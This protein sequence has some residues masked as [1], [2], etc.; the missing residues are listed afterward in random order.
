M[1]EPYSPEKNLRVLLIEDNPDDAL[2]IRL[3]L[4]QSGYHPQTLQVNTREEYLAVLDERVDVILSD[5]ALPRFNAIEALRLVQEKGLDLPFIIIS[6]VIDEETALEAL[7]LGA[8]DYLL[9]DR[10][11]RLGAAV[12]H[13]IEKHRLQRTNR[14]ILTALQESNAR[15]TALAEHMPGLIFQLLTR[16]DGAPAFLYASPWVQRTFGLAPETLRERADLLLDRIHPEDR[17]G[18]FETLHQAGA[19]GAPW[20]WEGRMQA[21]DRLLW[22]RG[23]ARPTANPDGT[24]LWNGLLIDLT[25]KKRAEQ[26]LRQSEVRYRTLFEAAHDAIV[27]LRE[28]HIIDCNRRFLTL[29]QQPREAVL[30]RHPAD[31]SP[32]GF[33]AG[34]DPRSVLDRHLEAAPAGKPRSCEWVFRR[35]DGTTFDAELS[36][37]AFQ[38]DDEVL[39]QVLVR[40]ITDQKRYEAGLIE[41]RERAEEMSRLKSALL[42]NMSHE[43]RTP[44]TG[45]LG[46]AEILQDLVSGEARKM[47]DMIQ[48]SARRLMTTLNSVLDLAQLESGSMPLHLQPVNLTEQ[49]QEALHILLPQ[50]K[51]SGLEVR[52]HL[53]DEAVLV[54]ADPGGLG[55]IL[56]NL[57]S[58][59]VKFTPA[60]HIE[61]TVA[62]EGDES[63]VRITD[64]GV[65]ISEAF[66]PHIFE[67]FKQESAGLDRN[68]EG[69]GLGLTITHRL[70][71]LMRGRIDVESEKH[72]GSTFTVHLPLAEATPAETVSTQPAPVPPRASDTPKARL[73]VVEDNP[74]TQELFAR[75]LEPGYEIAQAMKPDEA[76]EKLKAHPYDAVL[77]DINLGARLSGED[78]LHLLREMPHH[79]RTPVIACTAYALPGDSERF[80]QEG[81]DAYLPKPFTRQQ[82]YQILERLLSSAPE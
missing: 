19:T 75:L 21:E 49:V 1:T 64:T 44:L 71:T 40:D 47:A 24:T 42:T 78:L 58:N 43:I 32:P 79:A 13:A 72:R 38:L 22:V 46:F 59:A 77:M 74:E 65:G 67:A 51:R 20:Q 8:D 70:V 81:F 68:F 27:I 66:L 34:E 63:Y 53:P 62:C 11:T 55:R 48:L 50:I 25:E 31:F 33:P 37:G 52:L 17:P 7:R 15:F 26:A 14:A 82:L 54:W 29:L 6:G 12:E 76:L 3:A 39:L 61:I 2:L 69:T 30:G 41:A 35:R 45:I 18:F 23:V 16:P 10:I 4:E 73:L 56:L 60:G 9:K 28:K 57:I 80:L 36:I 5:H